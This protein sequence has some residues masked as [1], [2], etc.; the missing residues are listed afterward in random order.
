MTKV[1]KGRGRRGVRRSPRSQNRH[2]AKFRTTT[3]KSIGEEEVVVFDTRNP[4]K[5]L[6]VVTDEHILLQTDIIDNKE[7]DDSQGTMEFDDGNNRYGIDREE[8]K[9]LGCDEDI[10]N[11]NTILQTMQEE[12]RDELQEEMEFENENDRNAMEDIANHEED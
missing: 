11:E 1:N 7:D 6:S 8:D 5:K 2:T 9:I 10:T 4:I 3:N 12:G